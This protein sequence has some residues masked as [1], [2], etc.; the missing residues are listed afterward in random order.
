MLSA[1]ISPSILNS[2]GRCKNG[3]FC[4]LTLQNIC[5]INNQMLDTIRSIKNG[6][7]AQFETDKEVITF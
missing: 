6:E 2:S 7:P 3:S 1:S 4:S 5:F